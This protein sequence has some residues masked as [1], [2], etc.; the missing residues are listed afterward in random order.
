MNDIP[1]EAHILPDKETSYIAVWQT[2]TDL[3]VRI[4]QTDVPIDLKLDKRV[5]PYLV[6]ALI[7]LQNQ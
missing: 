3:F 5:L 1:Q 2:D 7:D 4:L 6:D